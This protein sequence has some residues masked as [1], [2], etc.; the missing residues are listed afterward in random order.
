M[1]IKLLFQVFSNIV[2]FDHYRRKKSDRLIIALIIA[3]RYSY[4]TTSERFS[5][6]ARQ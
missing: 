6:E 4:S 2:Q 5:R 1:R 3:I